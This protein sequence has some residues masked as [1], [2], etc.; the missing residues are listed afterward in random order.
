MTTMRA[1][2]DFNTKR[3]YNGNLTIEQPLQLHSVTRSPDHP[4]AKS[5]KARLPL[6]GP[7]L[8]TPSLSYVAINPAIH[9][10][11]PELAVLRFQHPVPLVG[12]VEHFGWDL[13]PL[14]G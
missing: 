13:Q 1:A 5:G 4:I 14:Q 11:V 12:E 8:G 6:N 10:F 9:G 7:P 3:L 2:M